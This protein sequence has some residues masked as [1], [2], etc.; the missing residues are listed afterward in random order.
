MS[1]T[2]VCSPWTFAAPATTS[3]VAMP[4]RACSAAP[5]GRFQA[6]DSG[7]DFQPSPNRAFRRVFLRRWKAEKCHDAVA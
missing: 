6:A 2:T 5:S 3:P 1:P 7:D 4:T